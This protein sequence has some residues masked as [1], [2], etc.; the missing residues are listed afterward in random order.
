VYVRPLLIVSIW[1]TSA[2]SSQP[3]VADNFDNATKMLD[4]FT[5]T[6][7]GGGRRGEG[8]GA[9]APSDTVQGAAFGMNEDME[10]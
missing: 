4:A 9:C 7:S 6:P 3:L 5:Q 8:G 2:N 10:F 1:W